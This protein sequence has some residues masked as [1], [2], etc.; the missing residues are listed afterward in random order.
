MVNA[1]DDTFL[2]KECYPIELAESHPHFH[3]EM[4]KYGGHCGFYEND[5]KGFV[6]FEKRAFEFVRDVVSLG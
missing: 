5:K 3:F 1:Q 4:P 6:W 2:S